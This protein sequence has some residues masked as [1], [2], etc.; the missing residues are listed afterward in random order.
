ME[1]IGTF[2]F[3]APLWRHPGPDSWF[4]VTVPPPESADIRELTV[5][6][7]RG[8]GS[9]R[10][11]A[12]VGRTVWRTSVFPQSGTGCYLLPVRKAVRGAED[13]DVDQPV[14]LELVLLDL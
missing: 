11:E 8:F 14:S 5:G 9:A 10:V 7:R 6:L 2:R 3:L 12:R 1:R 4:F 13:L